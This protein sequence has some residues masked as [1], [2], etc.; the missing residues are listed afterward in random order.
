MIETPYQLN[1][2]I[3]CKIA[4]HDS[5]AKIYYQDDKVTIF[6]DIHPAAEVHLLIIPNK[7]F[8]QLEELGED[9]FSI[10]ASLFAAARLIAAKLNL[11]KRGYRLILNNGVGAGQ[12]VPH[13]H[14]HLL[15][16]EKL[17]GFRHG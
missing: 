14:L 9:N 8:A 12:T 13:L 16:G 2:C 15:A 17:P 7:H 4:K 11:S 10:F 3:F 6:E 1:D 5:P